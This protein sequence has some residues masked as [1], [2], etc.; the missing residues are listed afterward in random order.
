MQWVEI[1]ETVRFNEID[2]W[3]VAWHGH[4]LNW[5]E[6]GRIALLK[7]F[8]LLPEQMVAM[9]Y[10]APIIRLVCEYK[11]PALSGDEIVIRTTALKP[12][13]AALVFKA[14]IHRPKDQALLARSEITQVLMTTEKTMIY[15]L[16]GEIQAR[17]QK[18]LAYCNSFAG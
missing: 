4:Y 7:R 1:A 12:E 16:S 2:Q 18:L 11:N 15:R 13:I 9:G 8:D 17:V 10:L 3:G 5:F 14:E 6:I